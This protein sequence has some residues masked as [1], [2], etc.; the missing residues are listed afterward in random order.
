MIKQRLYLA[1]LLSIIVSTESFSQTTEAFS[2]KQAWQAAFDSYPSLVEKQANFQLAEAEKQQVKQAFL[3]SLQL[4]VQ[5]SY[6][7]SS[8]TSGAFFPLPGIFNVTGPVG[9]GTNAA[10]SGNMFGSALADWKIFE[11]GRRR[12]ALKAADYAVKEAGSEINAAKLD[13]QIKV[14]RLYINMLYNQAK[15]DWA[16]Q[17]AARVKKILDLSASLTSAGLKPGADTL[18]ASATYLQTQA[19]LNEWE[20]KLLSS[21]IQFT[22]VVPAAP[23]NS[24]IVTTRFLNAY[25]DLLAGDSVGNSHPYLD[26]ISQRIL[27]NQAQHELSARKIFPSISILGGTSFR[28]SGISNELVDNSWPASFNNGTK[29]YL[30]GIGLTWNISNIYT[31]G[32]EKKM[33]AQQVN[34]SKSRY[35]LK[36]LQLRIGLQ[37]SESRISTQIKQVNNTSKAVVNAR[38]AYE[39]YL[40]RYENGLINLI[41]L[42]QIELLLQQSEKVNIE[43]YQQLW[44]QVIIKSELSGNFSDLSNQFN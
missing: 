16:A 36:L 38:S 26:G 43:A 23:Q 10:S 11:F 12:T 31:S 34:A 29:N 5:N 17:N 21:R 2:L 27:Q 39:L 44:D 3:P 18:L 33:A 1:V 30:V 25:T 20:G 24:R 19:E 40:S 8:G 22:E 15:A 13:L 6:G 35:E 9:P 28:A 32:I 4:Q 42:L 41:E 7:S 14:S 37:S